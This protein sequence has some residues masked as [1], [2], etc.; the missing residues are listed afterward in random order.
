[1]YL[2]KNFNIILKDM[3]NLLLTFSL[4]LIINY[5]FSQHS[6]VPIAG[7]ISS[8]NSISYTGGQLVNFALSNESGTVNSGVQNPQVIET[9]SI[10]EIND[11]LLNIQ[12]YPNP[13]TDVVIFKVMNGNGKTIYENVFKSTQ[14]TIDFSSFKSG[15]YF[16]EIQCKNNLDLSFKI[17]KN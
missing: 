9:N 11:L 12:I 1:M 15:V 6:I 8:G 5:S 10:I 7:N 16:I 17:I 3:N 13:T 4:S 2:S 14:E